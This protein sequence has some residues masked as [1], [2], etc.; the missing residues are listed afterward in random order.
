VGYQRADQIS[1]ALP[2]LKQ[3]VE[4]S[5]EIR[6]PKNPLTLTA[7]Y[8]LANGLQAAG[9]LDDALNQARKVLDLRIEVLSPQHAQT[10]DA[11]RLLQGIQLNRRDYADAEKTIRQ[12][13][14]ELNRQS[15]R[16]ETEIASA[17]TSLAEALLSQQDVPGAV[18]ELTRA[19][20]ILESLDPKP[21]ELYRARS[22]RGEV[23]AREKKWDEAEP[24]LLDSFDQLYQRRGDVRAVHRWY[25]SR[26]CE[27]IVDLYR[28]WDRPA[29]ASRWSGKLSEVEA[30]LEQMRDRGITTDTTETESTRQMEPPAESG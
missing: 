3:N 26:A 8:N 6:G 25:V 2:Y 4:L 21:N 18:R 12:W 29:E 30:E 9:Q 24:T 22:L 7:M 5:I 11:M 13:L 23:L 27:R 16:N 14:V 10:I 1:K 17:R 20:P 15:P 28:A 19:L